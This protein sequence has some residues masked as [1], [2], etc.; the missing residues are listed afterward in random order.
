MCIYWFIIQGGSNMTGTDLYV[1]KPHCTAA[2]QCGLFT[3]KSVPVIFEPPCISIEYS[4][5]HSRGTPTV[6]G[7][8]TVWICLF[9]ITTQIRV[10]G[11]AY[12]S[13]AWP[14][15]Q[16]HRT[17]SIV[18]LERWVCSCAELQVVSCYRGWKEACQA[19]RTISTTSRGKLSSSFFF[20]QGKTPK[21]I[22]ANLTETLGEHGPS[23]AT[24]K[25]WVAQFKR[26]DFSTC[27]APCP[28]WTKT[29]IAPEI[30]DQI[31]ELI[32]LDH[33]ISAK[34]IA[35]QLGISHERVGSIIH[36]D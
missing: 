11:G 24:I 3:Y 25:N 1:N 6:K 23:Y 32:L 14:T 5:M 30:I 19:T 9:C 12:K 22:Y 35:E 8:F 2:A 34:S 26:G 10:R 33:W 20:L 17:E 21:E 4:L 16:C 18:S 31:H 7:S 29:V 27:D 13:L 28:G 36:E 15:S